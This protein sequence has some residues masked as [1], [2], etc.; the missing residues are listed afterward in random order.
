MKSK[1]TL[2]FLPKIVYN[3]SSKLLLDL[4]EHFL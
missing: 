4:G 1:I 2:D 3:I